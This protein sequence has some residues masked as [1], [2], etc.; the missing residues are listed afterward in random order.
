MIETT[1]AIAHLNVCNCILEK[2]KIY[3]EP[4]NFSNSIHT[5]E[6][7]LDVMK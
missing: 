4:R 7:Y 1:S 5:V 2:N 6:K 3:S